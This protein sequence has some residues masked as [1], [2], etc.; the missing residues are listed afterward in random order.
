[1]YSILSIEYQ[2][3][4]KRN[5]IKSNSQINKYWKVYQSAISNGDGPG[6]ILRMS[7]E[8]DVSP[9]LIAKLI[10]KKYIEEYKGPKKMNFNVNRYLRDSYSIP[11]MDLAYEIY[12]VCI[13]SKLNI[14]VLI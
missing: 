9:C 4:M 6:I 7:E 10:L 13:Y 8:F 1:M 11:D 12:L 3:R 14:Y 5:H 2:R